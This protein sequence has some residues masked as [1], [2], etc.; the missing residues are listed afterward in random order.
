MVDC[1]RLGNKEDEPQPMNTQNKN[2][3]TY[4]R[5]EAT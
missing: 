5:K 1:D 2:V 4:L 3:K